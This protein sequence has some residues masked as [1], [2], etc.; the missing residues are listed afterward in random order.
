MNMSPGRISDSGIALEDLVDRADHRAEM[1]R[2]ALRERD[3][4][5]RAVEDRGRAVGALLDV[6]RER[7]AHERRAHLLGGREQKARDDFRL[8]R[9]YRRP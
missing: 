4:L 6:R 5:P 1:D 8:D 2:H 7:G 3:H 9:I